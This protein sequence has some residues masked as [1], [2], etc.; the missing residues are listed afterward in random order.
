MPW[1]HLDEDL[2]GYYKH[3]VN[4]HKNSRALRYG[5]YETVVLDDERRLYGF[6]RRYEQDAVFA[7][8]NGSEDTAE[9]VLAL[10][11]GDQQLWREMIGGADLAAADGKLRLRLEGRGSAWIMPLGSTIGA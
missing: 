1:D 7:V 10:G 11:E 5:R 9:V 4:I 8:F 2:L 6:V 3:I